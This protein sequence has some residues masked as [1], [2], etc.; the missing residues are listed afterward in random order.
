MQRRAPLN[1]KYNNRRKLLHRSG[2]SSNIAAPHNACAHIG[3][4]LK[5]EPI[6]SPESAKPLLDPQGPRAAFFVFALHRG[7]E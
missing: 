7:T 5:D 3:R 6:R 1:K 4:G 2:E